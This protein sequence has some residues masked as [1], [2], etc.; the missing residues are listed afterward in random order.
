[1]QL[2]PKP[3]AAPSAEPRTRHQRPV[4]SEMQ[5]PN[6]LVKYLQF[7]MRD[8]LG[9]MVSLWAQ[10]WAT[11]FNCLETARCSALQILAIGNVSRV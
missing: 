11:I 1:M 2:F 3:K 5:K 6:S 9:E 4:C 7:L 10:A 8:L